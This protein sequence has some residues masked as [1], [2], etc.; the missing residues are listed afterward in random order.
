MYHYVAGAI[1]ERSNV[2][3]SRAYLYALQSKYEL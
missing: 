3:A 2:G 1:L